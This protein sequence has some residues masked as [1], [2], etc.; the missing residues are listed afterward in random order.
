M[1]RPVGKVN[2]FR[3]WLEKFPAQWKPLC[4]GTAVAGWT[5]SCWRKVSPD[6]AAPSLLWPAQS[7]GSEEGWRTKWTTALSARPLCTSPAGSTEPFLC[8]FIFLL[9]LLKNLNWVVKR[10]ESGE[11][12]DRQ[13]SACLYTCCFQYE[14][15]WLYCQQESIEVQLPPFTSSDEWFGLH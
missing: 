6:S 5:N 8:S 13:K 11:L 7:A 4:W 3:H 2:R 15:K 10:F 9:L 1:K 12:L 14:E